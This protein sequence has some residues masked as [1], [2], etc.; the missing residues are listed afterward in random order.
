MARI[1]RGFHVKHSKSSLEELFDWQLKKVVKFS[2]YERQYRI[3]REIVGDEAGVRQGLK[4]T[5]LNDW[6][7][8]FAWPQARLGIEVQ[9]GTWKQ[10][11]GHNSGKGIQNDC[12]KSQQCALMGWQIIPVTGD[13]VRSGRALK[14]IE[15]YFKGGYNGRTYG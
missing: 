6:A 3:A 1:Y 2:R 11:T 10:N 4:E 9:G 15:N 12:N 8:D 7:I 5:G 14:F 13:D